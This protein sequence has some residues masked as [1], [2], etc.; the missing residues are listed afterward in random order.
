MSIYLFIDTSSYENLNFTFGGRQLS[1]VK[2]MAKNGECVLLYNEIVYREVKQHIADNLSSDIAN[3]NQLLAESRALAPYKNYSD[4]SVHLMPLDTGKMVDELQTKWDEYLSEC[5]AEKIEISTIDIND[6]IDRFFK[7]IL[8]FE[9][10][11]PYEFKDAIIIDSIRQF[12]CVH[13][14]DLICV[15]AKDKGFRKSF[16]DDKLVKTFSSIYE[17]INHI[18]KLDK[19]LAIE[20]EQRFDEYEYK[21]RVCKAVDSHLEDLDK[22]FVKDICDDVDVISAECTAVEFEYVDYCDDAGATI[23]ASALIELVVEYSERDDDQS[24]YDDE[25]EEYYW[26]VFNRFRNKY[27]VTKEIELAIEFGIECEGVDDRFE[28]MEVS[29]D[30]DFFLEEENLLESELI[31]TEHGE[32]DTDAERYCPDCGCII[33][34]ENDAGAFCINCAPN[35]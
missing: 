3:F 25:D 32:T 21:M 10:K 16:R 35:H 17:A 31:G 33:N 18:I 14:G 12:A 30:D 13:P 4:M 6:I 34:E 2:N 22:V 20:I 27:A 23:V 9:N 24:Y 29:I 28:S 5:S 1:K 26:E 11:K 7:R 15:V 8:P 19:N